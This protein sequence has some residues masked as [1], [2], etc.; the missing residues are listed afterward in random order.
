MSNLARHL[1]YDER[2]EL[3]LEARVRPGPRHVTAIG[4]TMVEV[5]ICADGFPGFRE[6]MREWLMEIAERVRATGDDVDFAEV[7][8]WTEDGAPVGLSAKPVE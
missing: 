5:W 4:L 8:G 6:S 2:G 3:R 7:Q 1:V